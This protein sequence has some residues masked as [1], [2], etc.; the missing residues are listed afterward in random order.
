MALEGMTTII[1]SAQ[2]CY[3]YYPDYSPTYYYEYYPNPYPYLYSPYPIYY[4]PPQ[5]LYCPYCGKKLD[6]HKCGE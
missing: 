5:Y 4:Y 6:A 1:A 2:G 3:E